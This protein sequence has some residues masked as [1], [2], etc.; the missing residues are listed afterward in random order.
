MAKEG[1][2]EDR[3]TDGVATEDDD[4]GDSESEDDKDDAE[5]LKKDKEAAKK[6]DKNAKGDAKALDEAVK[7]EDKKIAEA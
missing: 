5:E 2:S 3:G 4:E 7:I 1:T 6:W